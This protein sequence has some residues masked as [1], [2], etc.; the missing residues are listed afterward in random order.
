MKARKADGSMCTYVYEFEERRSGKEKGE[1]VE[2]SKK[3]N[4]NCGE[5]DHLHHE[6]NDI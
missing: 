6:G 2:K 4:K 5:P 3:S 1:G